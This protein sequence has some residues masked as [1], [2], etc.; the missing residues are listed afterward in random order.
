MSIFLTS[1]FGGAVAQITDIVSSAVLVQVLLITTQRDLLLLIS[2]A[3]LVILLFVKEMLTSVF[4][5]SDVLSPVLERVL[6][7]FVTIPTLAF[8]FVM[9][10]LFMDIA[11]GL[12]DTS[13]V[14]WN[15]ALVAALLVFAL[16]FLV[17]ERAKPKETPA[18]TRALGDAKS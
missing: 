9:L 3:L 15:D 18:A 16:T 14:R 12:F 1:I 10:R 7:Q 6:L 8:I 11:T 5:K 2:T 17:I 4:A 13:D